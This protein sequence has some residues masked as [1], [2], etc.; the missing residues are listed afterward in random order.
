[1]VEPVQERGNEKAANKAYEQ[2]HCS[3]QNNAFG[4]SVLTHL[5]NSLF[6][7]TPELEFHP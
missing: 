3:S 5:A 1:M 4:R 2:P 6:Q 7:R